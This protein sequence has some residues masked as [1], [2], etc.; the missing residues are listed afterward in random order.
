MYRI[1][2]SNG[3]E[4]ITHSDDEGREEEKNYLN[5]EEY[6]DGDDDDERRKS[7]AWKI[8]IKIGC[9]IHTFHVSSIFGA[10]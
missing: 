7:V 6:D 5:N 1:L 4:I 8:N 2:I 9:K 10:C 3:I